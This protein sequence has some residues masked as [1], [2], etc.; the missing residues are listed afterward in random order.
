MDR[1]RIGIAS[2]WEIST[3]FDSAFKETGLLAYS[4]SPRIRCRDKS[5]T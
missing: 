1:T 3:R 5:G 2:Q 4:L